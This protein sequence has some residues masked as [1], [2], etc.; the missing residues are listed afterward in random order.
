MRRSAGVPAGGEKS[1]QADLPRRCRDFQCVR[2]YPA[3][4][5]QGRHPRAGPLPRRGPGPRPVFFGEARG[6]GSRLPCRISYKEI[7]GE[8]G[9]PIPAHGHLTAWADQGVLLLNSVLSVECAPRRLAPGQGLGDVH[10]PG[11]RGGQPGARGRGV[12]AVGQLRPA[13]GRDHRPRA[14]LRAEGTAP[15]A[16]ECAPRI[17]RLRPFPAR[18]TST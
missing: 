1:G 13:Q 3:G 10:R 5:G 2:P 16:P 7:Q 14:P 12:H 15:L 9:L 4:P 18:P 11:D 17:F 6:T 8:L